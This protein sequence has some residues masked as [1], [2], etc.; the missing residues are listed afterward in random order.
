ME[1]KYVACMILHAL[2]DTIGFKNGEW[3][4]KQGGYDRTLEKLYEFIDLG[5]INNISLKDWRI[6]DDT[7]LH[8][9]TALSILQDFDNINKLGN[10][11]KK[12]YLDALK[13]FEKE[14]F[15]YRYPGL[16]T[17]KSLIQLRKGDEW[18]ST[19]YDIYSGGA[20][21]SMRNLC[22]GLAFFGEE[23]RYK[24]IQISIESSRVTHNS[25]IGYLGG[26]TSALFT[27]LAVEG[28]PVNEWPFILLNLFQTGVVHKYIK[29]SERDEDSYLKD[30]HIFIDKWHRYVE[31]KFDDNKQPIKR[32]SN[33]NLVYRG[34]YYNETFGYKLYRKNEEDE[35]EKNDQDLRKFHEPGF[36]GSGG[37]DSVIIAYDCLIDAEKVWEKLVI[38]S[39]LHIGDTDTTGAIAGGFYGVLYGFN[40]VPAHLLD[41]LE[42]KKE[43]T[44]IGKKLFNKFYKKR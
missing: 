6:S 28:K 9:K 40:D 35:F 27:A 42:Y 20:G 16:T 39:M 36:I 7:I 3:E 33:R 21:A 37:D 5:G 19:P 38:Y 43:L 30:Y 12:N 8:I 17:L 13:Q 29:A 23:N 24:L 4:F 2:G 22:I 15:E 44:D 26:M 34:K 18:N 11:F 41:F 32:K 1:E 10:I 25:V 31:D 14:G